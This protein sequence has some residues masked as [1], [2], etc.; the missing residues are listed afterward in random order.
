MSLFTSRWMF[1]RAPWLVLA[2]AMILALGPIGCAR[3][4]QPRSSWWQFWR[5][6]STE[7][8]S[9]EPE[10]IVLP[11][12]PPAM[13]PH[14]PTTVRGIGD[15]LPLPPAPFDPAG[16]PETE[17]P[18][19]ASQAVSE[20]RTV[21]FDFDCD[22]LSPE[23]QAVLDANAE[24]LLANPDYDIQIGGHCDERGSVEYNFNLGQRRARSVMGHLVSRGV[25]PERL[26]TISY[27]KEQPIALGRTEADY[28]LNRRAE[29][30][31][32]Y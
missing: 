4:T 11:P 28:A 8:A 23:T 9:Y 18:R 17:P 29:F 16:L 20:L 5:P 2:A 1:N 24:W 15:D 19:T 10:T 30:L 25:R 22:N 14:D 31:V 12:P 6:K 32:Y 13:D 21:H 7:L 27:G 3:S 26:H